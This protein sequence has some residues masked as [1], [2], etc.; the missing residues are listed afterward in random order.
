[1]V[2]V[3][4]EHLEMEK[5]SVNFVVRMA[6]LSLPA[7]IGLSLY[8]NKHKL[9]LI[10]NNKKVLLP[11]HLDLILNKTHSTYRLS[12]INKHPFYNLL[13]RLLLFPRRNHNKVLY[14]FLQAMDLW[15]LLMHL[16]CSVI[17]FDIMPLVLLIMS[18]LILEIW[19]SL[20]HTLVLIRL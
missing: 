20:N 4:E 3:V 16:I 14:L 1:M 13:L 2:E 5:F 10:S 18:Y 7:G 11:L 12:P 15:I 19:W 17:P 6:I 8:F 9:D